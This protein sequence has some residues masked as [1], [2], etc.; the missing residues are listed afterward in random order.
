MDTDMDTDMEG[1][2]AAPQKAFSLR[3]AAS[4]A[5][6]GRCSRGRADDM[7]WE[8]EAAELAEE[9][10]SLDVSSYY[11]LCSSMQAPHSS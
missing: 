2:H 10:A 6:A 9:E 11:T 1:S 4:R 5:S 3:A 8:I 7:D